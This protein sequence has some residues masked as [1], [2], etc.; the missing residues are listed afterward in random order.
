VKDHKP[1]R[2]LDSTGQTCYKGR[3]CA[4]LHGRQGALVDLDFEVP[5]RWYPERTGNDPPLVLGADVDVYCCRRQDWKLRVIT[6]PPP[7]LVQR[8]SG[9]RTTLDKLSPGDGPFRAVVI[10]CTV[11]GTL[12]DFNCEVSGR[13]TSSRHHPKGESLRVY[14]HEVDVE[15]GI[16]LVSTMRHPLWQQSRKTPLEEL[17]TTGSVMYQGTVQR[18]TSTNAFVDLNCEVPGVIGALDIDIDACPDGLVEGHQVKVF[19]TALNL[20]KRMVRLSM[21]RPKGGTVSVTT[22]NAARNHSNK[23]SRE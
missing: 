1:L 4:V 23:V 16:C 18:V 15:H 20:A 14:C 17:D 6:S 7:R 5:A 21:F 10:S 12:V 8:G 9:E 3:V 19:I 11:A 22:A 2:L 13:L